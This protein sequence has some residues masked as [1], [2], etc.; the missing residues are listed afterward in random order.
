M[1]EFLEGYPD[2]VLAVKVKGRLSHE[3]YQNKLI[4]AAEAK[5]E[6]FGKIGCLFYIGEEYSGFDVAAMWDDT[7]FGIKH[8]TDFD[9]CAV[10]TDIDWIKGG[11][12]MFSPLIPAEIRVYS[13]EEYEDAKLWISGAAEPDDKE[14]AVG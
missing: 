9:K 13:L 4:P 6:R 14:S 1:I 12:A 5:M 11:V 7:L 3:D 8:W 10:V 2:N